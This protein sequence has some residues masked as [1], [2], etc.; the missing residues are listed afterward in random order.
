MQW[1]QLIIVLW[2]LILNSFVFLISQLLKNFLLASFNFSL[3]DSF[4][5]TIVIA[6]HTPR[7]KVIQLQIKKL[8][9]SD[10]QMSLKELFIFWVDSKPIPNV[11]FFGIHHENYSNQFQITILPTQSGFI[12]DRFL[13]PYSLQTT[14]VL[15]MDDDLNM[16][17]IEIENSFRIYK[18]MHFENRIFGCF[19]RYFVDDKYI[20]P[21]KEVTYNL[22]LTGFAFLNF[23]MLIY[24]NL[25]QY[26]E[27]RKFCVKIRNCDDILMNYIVLHHL[28]ISPISINLQYDS[29]G[30]MGISSKPDHISKRVL[31]CQHFQKF[32]GYDVL[33]Y[34]QTNFSI[35]KNW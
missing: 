29:L 13:V 12:T 7:Q 8:L 1:N 4:S 27:L 25:P 24:Y 15:T 19:P 21:Q 9:N 16:D 23:D 31:C 32:F 33:K 18:E 34:S 20:I 35:K 28:K 30:D 14:T 10:I 17:P 3:L 22:V 6:T 11:E 2:C 26:E 5:Y